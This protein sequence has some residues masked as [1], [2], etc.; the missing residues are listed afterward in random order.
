MLPLHSYRAFV[1]YFGMA[2]RTPMTGKV[3]FRRRSQS[4][5]DAYERRVMEKLSEAEVGELTC[6]GFHGSQNGLERIQQLGLCQ[7]RR[8]HLIAR[9]NPMIVRVGDTQ[10]G[11]SRRL[12]DLI[13]VSRVAHRA[14]SP[15]DD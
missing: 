11:V 14:E 7:H 15:R 3:A 6:L 10:I 4:P 1:G 12:A 5:T 8:F 13:H 2:M 9:G